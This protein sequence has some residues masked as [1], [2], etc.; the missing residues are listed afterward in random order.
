MGFGLGA[1]T[2]GGVRSD[3]EVRR[4]KRWEDRLVSNTES[5]RCKDLRIA[6]YKCGLSC[7]EASSLRG[8][9]EKARQKKIQNARC[10]QG[11]KNLSS[12]RWNWTPASDLFI[13]SGGTGWLCKSSRNSFTKLKTKH[14][15]V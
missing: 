4:G 6:R 7:A 5:G 1:C 14:L 3:G 12:P 8:H 9:L 2:V 15:E 13:R 10:N 11:P